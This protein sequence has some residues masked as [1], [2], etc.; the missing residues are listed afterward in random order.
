MGISLDAWCNDLAYKTY[1]STTRLGLR[2][3]YVTS[4][5]MTGPTRRTR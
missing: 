3:C 5:R 1:N 2:S 4:T